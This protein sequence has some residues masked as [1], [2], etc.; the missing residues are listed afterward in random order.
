MTTQIIEKNGRKEF[1]VLPYKQFLRMQQ[2]LEDYEDL[3]ILRKAKADPRN[4]RSR[5]LSDYMRERGI[6]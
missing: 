4:R 2:K 6:V 1:A 3:M 5:P